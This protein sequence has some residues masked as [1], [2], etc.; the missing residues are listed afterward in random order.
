MELHEEVRRARKELGLSQ[1]QLAAKVGLQ[2]R[3]ISTL[4]RGGNVTLNTLKRVLNYLPNLQEF[5]FEQ[6][7]MKPEYRDVPPFEWDLFYVE[8]HRFLACVEDLTEAVNKWVDLPRPGTDESTEPPEELAREMMEILQRGPGGAGEEQ[9]AE[10]AEEAEE[11][12]EPEEG[13]Q[14]EGE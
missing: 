11:E 3:Q 13:E 9:K 2:R 14:S 7:R 12:D 6:I 10:E 5:T 4:E 8:M 1:A